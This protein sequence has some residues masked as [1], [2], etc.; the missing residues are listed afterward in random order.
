ME[1]RICI[2]CE[3]KFIFNSEIPEECPSYRGYFSLFKKSD[4]LSNIY[5]EIIIKKFSPRQDLLVPTF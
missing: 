4:L 1:E 2:D 5:T 3:E